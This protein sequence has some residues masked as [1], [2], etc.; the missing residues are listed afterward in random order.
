[1]FKEGAHKMLV[2]LTPVVIFI[3]IL[4]ANFAPI[5]LRQKNYKA[6]PWT[7]CS[8]TV[9]REKLCKALSYKKDVPNMLV[10]LTP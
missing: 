6:K 10:K 7:N 8:Q 3:N 2:K 1:L 4:W 9:I 5:F